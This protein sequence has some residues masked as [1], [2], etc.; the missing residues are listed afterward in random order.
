MGNTESSELYGRQ[1]ISTAKK[2]FAVLLTLFIS[3]LSVAYQ[4]DLFEHVDDLLKKYDL[5]QIDEVI[6]VSSI[7]SIFVSLFAFRRWREIR[8]SLETV[9]KAEA[10]L[11]QT[12]LELKQKTEDLEFRIRQSQKLSRLANFLQVCKSKDEMF[13]FISQSAAKLFNGTSGALYITKDSRNQLFKATAWGEKK[14]KA[15][16]FAPDDCWGLRIGNRYTSGPDLDRPLCGHLAGQGSTD[17]IC[18]PL[19]AYGEIIGLLHIDFDHEKSKR[20]GTA[21]SQFIESE[22]VLF[23]KQTS[24]AI[25]NLTLQEKL[26]YMAINDPLTG[27]YNRQY[28]KETFERELHRVQRSQGQLAVVMIDLDYF[29]KFNDAFGHAAGDLLLV[30]MGRLL[31]SFFR[32]EDFCCRFGGEEFLVLL[33]GISKDDLK[34]RCDLFRR[35]LSELKLFYQ[36]RPLGKVTCSM[37][38]AIFPWNGENYSLLLKAADKALYRAKN[39]GRDRVCFA[40]LS[41]DKNRDDKM[42]TAEPIRQFALTQKSAI[43]PVANGSG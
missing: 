29:K 34:A 18:I 3:M 13:Q 37:G 23:A 24:L 33:S 26:R 40:P 36:D 30:E 22:S 11:K 39:D 42:Q 17:P 6:I 35:R 32:M 27:L 38:V 20:N 10:V 21:A 8:H 2:D 41:A 5:F 15:D 4:I 12:N 1:Q 16:V 7:F 25:S 43:E 28:L 9:K 19:T 14:L 31:K